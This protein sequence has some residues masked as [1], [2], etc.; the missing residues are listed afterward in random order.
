MSHRFVPQCLHESVSDIGVSNV[1]N[2][3][4]FILVSGVLPVGFVHIRSST[5]VCART[6]GCIQVRY[7]MWPVLRDPVDLFVCLFSVFQRQPHPE[8]HQD[9][10][11]HPPTSSPCPAAL[12]KKHNM[13]ILPVQTGW[14]GWHSN[15]R[16]G[17]VPSLFLSPHS[18][19]WGC[20]LN[21]L[22]PIHTHTH[23]STHTPPPC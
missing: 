19:H 2:W 18:L 10:Y 13:Q 1:L 6:L 22:P 16:T 5:G 14:W 11:F 4:H 9:D 3:W 21:V 23:Q 12:A 15:N 20:C 7:C 8:H 17:F